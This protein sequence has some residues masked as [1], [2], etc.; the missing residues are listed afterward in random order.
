MLHRIA[1]RNIWRN[2]RRSAML[3]SAIAVGTFCFLGAT[4]F[5]DG[6]AKQMLA[7][8]INLQ[9]GHIQVA[10]EGFHTNPTPEMRLAADS[11]LMAQMDAMVGLRYA[12]LVRAAGLA[13]SAERSIGIVLNG[14]APEK[15][16]AWNGMDAQVVEG[17]WFGPVSEG[18]IM[19]KAL[20]DYLDL[21]LGEKMVVLLNDVNNELQSGAFRIEGIVETGNSLYDKAN[22]FLPMAALQALTGQG[23]ALTLVTIN[24]D[25]PDALE[26]ITQELRGMWSGRGAEV[27]TWRERIPFLVITMQMYDYSVAVLVIILFTAVAFTIINSF[28]MVILERIHELGIMMANGVRPAQ[29]RRM[30]FLEAFF[31]ALLGLAAGSVLA[32]P[33]LWFWSINGLDLSQFSEGLNVIGVQAVIYPYLDPFHIVLGISLIFTIVLLSVSW[34][35]FRASRYQVVEAINHV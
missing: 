6:M 28:L 18:I 26:P 19:G 9:G 2:P 30:L 4:A 29:V 32:T 3:I 27:L 13:S 17:A 11:A 1:W 7:N 23:S 10:P 16:A 14:I 20:A 35:A 34:P 24:L 5:M 12:P 8:T 31:V 25:D 21:R 22:V 15:M 33:M